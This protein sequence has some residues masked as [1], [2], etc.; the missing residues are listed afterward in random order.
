MSFGKGC[1]GMER[2]RRSRQWVWI[3]VS[4]VVVVVI[5]GILLQPLLWPVVP[6]PA[7]TTPIESSTSPAP[8]PEPEPS[9]TSAPPVPTPVVTPSRAPVEQPSG[10]GPEGRP[11]LAPVEPGEAVEGED[12][13]WIALTSIEHVQGE[14]VQPGEVAGPAVRV[15]VTITNAGTGTLNVGRTVV[16][17]Y[18]GADRRPAGT[19]VRPGGVPFDGQLGE[20]ETAYGVYLFTI[21]SGQQNDVVITVDY[22]VEAPVV[23]FAG[24]LG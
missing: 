7:V 23:V 13:V 6:A 14:A 8:S 20:G 5:A 4:A 18:Y 1:I 16:N 17:G 9:R 3:A 11:E 24:D 15:T 2:A 21:P 19:L 12:G 22:R 10:S